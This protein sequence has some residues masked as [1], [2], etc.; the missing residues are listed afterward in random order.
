LVRPFAQTF[1][2]DGRL[3]AQ[4]K[5]CLA[6]SRELQAHATIVLE[7]ARAPLVSLPRPKP[8][9][10]ARDPYASRELLELLDEM[11]VLRHEQH[12]L[13]VLDEPLGTP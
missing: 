13:G 11:L 1:E 6:E 4:S 10:A 12:R 3:A 2:V 8:G 9:R 5:R 7:R